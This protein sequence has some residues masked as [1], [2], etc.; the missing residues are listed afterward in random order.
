M[1]EP[2]NVLWIGGRS[3][4]GKSTVARLLARRHGLRWFSC[5]TRTWDHRDR[6]IAAGDAAAIEWEQLSPRQRSQ[7]S[8]EENLR[9]TIDRSKMV[10]DDV[11]A[12][13]NTPAVVVE[14][15]PVVP[16][17]VPPRSMAIW[18]TAEPTTRAG[19]TRQRGWGAGGGEV[20]MIKERELMA[21]LEHTDAARIDTTGQTDPAE[22]LAK[23]ETIAADWLGNRP[24][25]RSR[26]ERQ[27]L[28]REG[29][30]AIVSQ[31]RGGMIRAGNTA[32]AGLVRAYDCECGQTDCTAMVERTLGSLP[33]PF[34]PS[35]P[36]ILAL[37][38]QCGPDSPFAA[39]IDPTHDPS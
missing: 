12:L 31:Y 10:L 23:I 30:A 22:T 5:D 15:T 20:D 25:A 29:N 9:L 35:A 14:G 13:P 38:H 24:T 21:E 2:D 1:A 8:T 27:S 37:G 26:R 19:R 11:A 3:G 18:L 4:A 39:E 6:A 28:I 34:T 17:M 7:L 36:P 32:G 33:E 16:S